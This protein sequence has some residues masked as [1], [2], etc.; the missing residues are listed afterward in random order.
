MRSGFGERLARALVRVAALLAPPERRKRFVREWDAELWRHARG[1]SGGEARGDIV[2]VVL[3]AFKDAR[4]LVS[5][6]PCPWAG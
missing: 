3:G 5:E 6:W 1:A 2:G 4:S